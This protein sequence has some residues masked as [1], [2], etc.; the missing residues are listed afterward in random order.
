[1]DQRDNSHG[2]HFESSNWISAEEHD[3]GVNLEEDGDD[4]DFEFVLRDP[5]SGKEITV[6]EMFASDRIHPVFPLF[7]RPLSPTTAAADLEPETRISMQRLLIEERD[8][9]PASTSSSECDELESIPDSAYCPWSPEK[10]RRSA[11]AGGSRRWRLMDLVE[12]RSRSD[13]NKRFVHMPPEEKD[14]KPTSRASKEGEKKPKVG[15][16]TELD[17][18][19]AHKLYYSKKG[20]EGMKAGHKSSLPYRP[21]FIGFF[22]NAA[23]RTRSPF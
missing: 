14:K 3:G 5:D 13:G 10:Q 9:L 2:V 11:S 20:G 21:E 23:R 6:D 8:S 19:T 4:S 17:M 18:V 15:K 22:G 12:G 16:V 1:M 7:G